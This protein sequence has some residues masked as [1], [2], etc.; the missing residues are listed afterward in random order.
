M[1][2]EAPE[3]RGVFRSDIAVLPS[4]VG[5]K[6]DPVESVRG[7][8]CCICVCVIFSMV[9]VGFKDDMATTSRNILSRIHILHICTCINISWLMETGLLVDEC[10]EVIR[11]DTSEQKESRRNSQSYVLY[12]IYNK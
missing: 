4:Y 5:Q 11:N 7:Q 6:R 10:I 8:V 1:R 2:K 12:T 9:I 3:D